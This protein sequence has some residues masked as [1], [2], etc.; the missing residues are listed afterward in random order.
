MLEATAPPYGTLT[1]N[2]PWRIK[3]FSHRRRY[4]TAL[5]LLGLAKSQRVLDYGSGDGHLLRLALDARVQAELWAYEPMDQQYRQLQENSRG[6][7]INIVRDTTHLED[8]AFDRIACCEV[9]EH[10]PE[11]D[12]RKL[13]L[14]V[15]RLLCPDGLAVLSVPIEVGLSW[16][17]KSLVRTATGS[18]D[19]PRNIGTA[20]R[21]VFGARIPRNEC[22]GYIWTHVGFR[23]R[24]LEELLQQTGMQ[25][26]RRTFSPFPQLRGWL[27]CQVLY[28]AR[29][30][31]LP[32]D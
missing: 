23:Y 21:S 15:R 1:V 19:H 20:V 17:A 9:L 29:K 13:L 28:A 5:R 22:K 3:R 8:A 7:N 6:T 10:L 2:S 12:Q 16:L 32:A 31:A 4:Q 27:N 14:D 18:P 30:V 11:P 25:V 26:V 24:D